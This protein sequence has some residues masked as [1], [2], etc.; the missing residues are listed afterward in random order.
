MARIGL[1]AYIDR[2]NGD[3]VIERGG[4][5]GRIVQIYEHIY[6]YVCVYIEYIITLIS[7]LYI[8]LYLF[9]HEILLKFLL[10]P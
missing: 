6:V 9:H 10:F 2:A 5:P 8:Y 1:S 4:I 7:L 3:D